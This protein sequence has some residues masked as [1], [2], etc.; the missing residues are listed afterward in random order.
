VGIKPDTKP[1]PYV[2]IWV[3]GKKSKRLVLKT[4]VDKKVLYQKKILAIF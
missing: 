1:D 3:P 2:Q 4:K